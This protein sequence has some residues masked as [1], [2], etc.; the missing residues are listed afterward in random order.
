MKIYV[1][2]PKLLNKEETRYYSTELIDIDKTLI[3]NINKSEEE[4]KRI[5][6]NNIIYASYTKNSDSISVYGYKVV[7]N[8][9]LDYGLEYTTIVPEISQYSDYVNKT[10]D[11]MSEREYV[12]NILKIFSPYERYA[13]NINDIEKGKGT[14]RRL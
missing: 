12:D 9:L 11:R 1:W 2:F 14:W 7:I 4:L 10:G 13:I 8:T 6:Y 5:I 3:E